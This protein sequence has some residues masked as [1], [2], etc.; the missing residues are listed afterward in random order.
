MLGADL[1]E[2]REGSNR[3]W[4]LSRDIKPQYPSI[5]LRPG[6]FGYFRAGHCYYLFGLL[7]GCWTWHRP[8]GS[9]PCW[10]D[11][12]RLL[13][14]AVFVR[15]SPAPSLLSLLQTPHVKQRSW[16]RAPDSFALDCAASV[17]AP[18]GAVKLRLSLSP[19]ARRVL[20]RLVRP[21]RRRKRRANR[22][23]GW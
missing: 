11:P 23:R 4:R 16:L 18:D 2:I 21:L 22:C 12:V 13:P 1:L 9:M 17:R 15:V 10:F 7:A 3:P 19:P 20:C 6:L 8:D 14:P 5:I